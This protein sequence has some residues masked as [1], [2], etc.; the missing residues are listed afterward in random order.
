MSAAAVALALLRL[1]RAQRLDRATIEAL[2][3]RRLRAV[4]A[5]A[6][7]HVPFWRQLMQA[8]RIVPEDIG[9]LA[10]LA[11]FPVTSR[12]ELQRVPAAERTSRAFAA[13]TLQPMLTT[14]ST[15]RPL[16][17]AVEPAWA[18]LRK[19]LFLRALMAHGLWPGR[20]LLLVAH[21]RGRAAP[22]W[23]RWRYA[24]PDLPA[25]ELARLFHATAPAFLYGWVTPLRHLA[26]EI[27]RA[28]G[29]ARKVRHVFTT[30]E[31]LDAPTAAL[32]R[33]RL[34][35][36]V[37]SIY[38]TTELGTLGW[39]CPAAAG[40]HLAE[41]TTLLEFLPVPGAVGACRLVATSLAALAT[42]L[43][44]YDTGD[45]APP[46]T[47]ARCACGGR[48]ARVARIDGRLVDSVSLR[49]GRL[50]SPFV[51]TEA[52]EA[53]AG[54]GRF[55]IVQEAAGRFRVRLERS[56]G[57]G[58]SAADAAEAVA[59]RLRRAIPEPVE[60]EVTM[61]ASLDPPPGRKFRVV[62][63]RVAPQPEPVPCAS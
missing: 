11:C 48:L 15:G 31:A 42:P 32:L 57:L 18:G 39:E 54:L 4:V 41:D 35:G 22:P 47:A 14:G 56:G 25:A 8:H 29:L 52:V 10:D 60:V 27:G 40:L 49:D 38:G 7:T 33:E 9:S 30:A 45:L 17:I 1:H 21:D 53:V 34:G 16:T 23:L 6:Y 26:G 44:R 59:A 58:H 12:A 63:S 19:A 37:S 50:L 61:E 24:D 28:G 2:Q 51:L 20:S 36:T 5:H 46:P 13:A 55:Q 3:L 62:E 43:I